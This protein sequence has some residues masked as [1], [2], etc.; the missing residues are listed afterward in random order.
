MWYPLL[1]Q[2][3]L[4]LVA[5][6]PWAFSKSTHTADTE[7]QQKPPPDLVLQ[8][9]AQNLTGVLLLNQVPK[10][11]ELEKLYR[12][13]EQPE[14][15]EDDKTEYDQEGAMYFAVAVVGV[16]GLTIGLLIA[17]TIKRDINDYEVKKF[18]RHKT[19]MHRDRIFHRQ[20]KQHAKQAISHAIA[21]AQTTSLIMAI[22]NT[23]DRIQITQEQMDTSPV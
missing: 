1:P 23:T 10:G 9:R 11:S 12:G 3:F 22:P 4:C 19:K 18:L 14:V 16:Y 6:V 20:Q 8:F 2:L 21:A 15:S 13:V 17:L 7:Q 5:A